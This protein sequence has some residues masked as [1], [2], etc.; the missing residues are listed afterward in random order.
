MIH[1]TRGPILIDFGIAKALDL[2]TLT[3]TGSVVGTPAYMAPE[4]FKGHPSDHRG[5]IHALAIV[6]YYCLTGQNPWRA[7][8]MVTLIQQMSSKEMDVCHLPASP[9]LRAVVAKAGRI[10]PE[11]RYRHASE[12]LAAINETPEA[13]VPA[14]PFRKLWDSQVDLDFEGNSDE[15]ENI[16]TRL[17]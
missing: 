5:D 14:A 9:A 12:L 11:E 6:I 2:P 7:E 1:P 13:A 15:T 17:G 8:D 3:Q 16:R 4:Q 10:S